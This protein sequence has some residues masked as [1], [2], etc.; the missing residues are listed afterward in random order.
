MHSGDEVSAIRTA[1]VPP[2]AATGPMAASPPCEKGPVVFLDYTRDELDAAYDQAA[3]MPHI[4]QLRDRWHSNSAR[5]RARIGPPLRRRYGPSAI[6]EL[7]IFRTH[8]PP[9]APVFV[10]IH[11]GAWRAGSAKQ[12]SAPAEMFG[13]SGAH[14]VAPDFVTVQDA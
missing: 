9:R 2:A 4:Q 1:G 14:Y 8:A 6:E 12:Y 13:R 7:D 3:Y 10:F 11:G 5:T